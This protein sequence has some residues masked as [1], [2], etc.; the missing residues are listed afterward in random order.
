MRF[1]DAFTSMIEQFK[2]NPRITFLLMGPPGCGKTACARAVIKAL[3]GNESNTAE[4]I[5]SLHEPVDVNG[6]PRNVDQPYTSWVPPASFYKLRHGREGDARGEPCFLLLD[7]M[8]DAMTQMQNALCRVIYDNIAG[9]L[10]LSD[11]CI[12]IATGNRTEDKSGAQRLTTKLANRVRVINFDFNLDDWVSWAI[13]AGIRPDVIQF[14]RFRPDLAMDF[15]PMRITNPTARAWERVSD[16]PDTLRPEVYYE[17][18]CGEVGEGAAAEFTG[19]QRIYKSIPNIDE[20][21]RDPKG[22]P[23]P[24]PGATM[25]A[26]VGALAR[27]ATKDNFDAIYEYTQRLPSDFSVMLVQDAQRYCPEIKDTRAFVKWASDNVRVM[28]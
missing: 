10:R 17:N 23:V 22:A 26:L 15:D 8:T 2:V 7:E 28:F 11:H 9:D 20:I 19:F 25:F 4:V 21:L 3:G 14:L 18:V 1:Q 13:D 6:T 16:I 24:E 12:K 27:R 5:A